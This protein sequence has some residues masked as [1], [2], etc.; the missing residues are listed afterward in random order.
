MSDP[1]IDAA[2]QHIAT[3]AAMLKEGSPYSRD[4]E[5]AL[6]DAKDMMNHLAP[7]E[8]AE[9]AMMLLNATLKT[10][11]SSQKVIR[12]ISGAAGQLHNALETH[13][14]EFPKSLY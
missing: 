12:M 13:S 14:V 11:D 2:V 1:I 10:G 9:I 7:I 5:N 4:F 6:R 3:E 8:M